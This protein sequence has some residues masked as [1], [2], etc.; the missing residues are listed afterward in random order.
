MAGG[1]ANY[2]KAL[3]QLNRNVETLNELY[4]NKL[5][6]LYEAQIKQLKNGGSQMD[7]QESTRKLADEIAALNEK[8]RKMLDTMN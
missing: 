1:S 7:V 3:E 2:Q 8:Y 6:E 4:I 5:N